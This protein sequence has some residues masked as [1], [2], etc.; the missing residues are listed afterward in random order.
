MRLANFLE[1]PWRTVPR[2]RDVGPDLVIKDRMTCLASIICTVPLEVEGAVKETYISVLDN[3]P[4]D[5][6]DH[7][8]GAHN[9]TLK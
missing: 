8:V 9:A 7:I 3:V 6:V 1:V 2:F 4:V 5:L